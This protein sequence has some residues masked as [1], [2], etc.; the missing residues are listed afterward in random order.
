MEG[1]VTNRVIY[2]AVAPPINRFI[3]AKTVSSMVSKW[4]PACQKLLRFYRIANQLS[5]SLRIV[6][7]SNRWHANLRAAEMLNVPESCVFAA[8]SKMVV[9]TNRETRKLIRECRFSCYTWIFSFP[10]IIY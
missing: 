3:H 2:E 7:C 10:V 8:A 4:L 1:F 6:R 5:Q 9:Q